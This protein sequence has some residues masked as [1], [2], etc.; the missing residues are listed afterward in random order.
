VYDVGDVRTF[1]TAKRFAEVGE[2]IVEATQA[3]V[4]EVKE[5]TFPGPEHAFKPNGAP[6]DPARTTH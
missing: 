3:Y 5:R 4:S 2:A 1:S 6:R